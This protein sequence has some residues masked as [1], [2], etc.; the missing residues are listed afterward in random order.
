MAILSKA[1]LYA[2]FADNATGDITAQDMRNLV[3]SS[4]V[5]GA[6]M[7]LFA[8]VNQ[9]FV[10][11]TWTKLAGVTAFDDP[12]NGAFTMPSNNTLENNLSG[13]GF[14]CHVSAQ[15]VFDDMTNNRDAF[16]AIALNGVFIPE[17]VSVMPGHGPN[18]PLT[19]NC[20]T[21]VVISHGDNLSLWMKTQTAVTLDMQRYQLFFSA[22]I[23]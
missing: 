14:E 4:N 21:K 3:D 6:G 12:G 5:R 7:N 17:S 9:A 11:D 8:P 2:A 13:L 23:T 16:M 20:Q 19:M 15:A 18:D 10:S 1:A 22:I